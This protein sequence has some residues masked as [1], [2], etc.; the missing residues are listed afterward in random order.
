MFFRFGIRN[1]RHGGRRN[2]SNKGCRSRGCNFN[3]VM[4]L[5]SGLENLQ[6]I[7]I[8]NT[9]RKT[10]EMGI[11]PGEIIFIHKNQNND[12]NLIIGVGESRIIIS[13]VIAESIK[14]R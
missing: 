8:H 2:Y 9:N 10:L 13:R 12:K 6:Y 5:S 7:V 1:N 11:V 3:Q 4:D 14:V